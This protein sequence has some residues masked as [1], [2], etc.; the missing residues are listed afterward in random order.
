MK[1][2]GLEER[3]LQPAGWQWHN[4]MH[5][6]R[7]VRFGRVM[8]QNPEAIIVCLPGLSE[9][10]EKYYE[11]AHDCLKRNFG[12]YVIDWL[13]QGK[14]ERLVRNSQKRHSLGYVQ[15]VEVLHTLITQHIEKNAPLAMLAHSMGA[16]IGLHY[17]IKH[18]G[19]FSCACLSAPLLAVKGLQILPGPLA[20]LATRITSL[21]AP[22]SYVAGFSDWRESVRTT[23]ALNFFSGD[24]VRSAIHNAWC[25]A[26]PDLQVGGI[27]YGWLYET[28]KSCLELWRKERLK[29]VAIPCVIGLAGRENFVSNA[30]IRK[31]ASIMPNA[32]LLEFPDSRHEILMESDEIRNKLLDAF[33]ELIRTRKQG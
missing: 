6:G 8:P 16:H 19:I 31:A 12:F 7:Q 33:Y 14:S 27:T 18:P 24:E 15:D 20:G 11:T 2:P 25:L 3:F 9:F 22:L 21:L 10:A 5:N 28:H 13:G 29:S 1:T 30:A 17:L 32:K 4:F 23:P 26:D